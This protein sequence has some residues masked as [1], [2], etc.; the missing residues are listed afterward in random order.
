MTAVRLTEST[1]LL[2]ASGGQPK[3]RRFRAR[4]IAGD[5]QGSSGFYP[6]AMLR[7]SAT[8]FG[9]GLPMYID[10]PSISEAHDRPER[11]VR[12]LAGRLASDARYEADGLY[13][14]IEVYP[15][16][17]PIIEA[18]ADDIGLSIRASGTVE[19][20]T[21]DRIRGPIV[22]R[23]SEAQSVDFVTAAG[24]GGRL[25]QLL[26]SARAQALEERGNWR[27]GDH[28]RDR[29]GRFGHGNGGGSSSRTGGGS[30]AKTGSG[31][32]GG[33]RTSAVQTSSGS[34]TVAS[35]RDGGGTL[36]IGGTTHELSR[37]E[38]KDLHHEFTLIANSPLRSLPVG[39]ERT[40]TSGDRTLA[41]VKR[42]GA[43]DFTLHMTPSPGASRDDVAAAPGTAL[44]R[45]DMGQIDR[46]IGG[47][48]QAAREEEQAAKD[49]ARQAN[50]DAGAVNQADVTRR[51]TG[52][53]PTLEGPG[54]KG[55]PG[56]VASTDIATKNS[57][58]I[59][60]HREAGDDF[61]HLT[62]GGRSYA[63][64]RDEMDRMLSAVHEDE[65]KGGERQPLAD[66]DGHIFGTVTDVG[67]GRYEVSIDGQDP[68]TL[69]GSD[70]SRIE[71]A[72]FELSGARRFDGGYGAVDVIP[73]KD[74][75]VSV[76]HLGDDGRPVTVTFDAKSA[77]A[78]DHALD[79]VNEGF[80]QFDTS[81]DAPT[82][83]VTSQI[84]KTNVGSVEVRLNGGAWGAPG[85]YLTIMPTEGDAWGAAFEGPQLDDLSD[86]WRKSALLES[87]RAGR[88]DG[89]RADASNLRAWLKHMP[90]LTKEPSMPG[91]TNLIE[92]RTIGAWVESRLHLALTT[93]GDDM[94]GDGRLTREE[95]ITL[96]SAVGDA[97]QAFTARVEADAP[98]LYE[99]GPYDDP[100]TP[101][102]GE[103]EVSEA[104]RRLAEAAGITANDLRDAISA[105]VRDVYSG[106]GIHV[107][108][109]D[110]TDTWVVFC[111]TDDMGLGDADLFQQ[112]YTLT[113]R[114]VTLSGDP[115][116]VRAVT[117]YEPQPETE[118]ETGP[119]PTK[120]GPPAGGASTK[121]APGTAPA[122][123]TESEGVMPELTEEQAR[124]L[125][126]AA[127]LSTQLTEAMARLDQAGTQIA[128]LTERADAADARAAEANAKAQR[129]ENEN[130]ARKLVTEA[131][132]KSGIPESSHSG[133]TE[134]VLRDLP[135]TEQGTLD[136]SAF[137]AVVESAMT[138]K[139]T[140]IASLL[141]AAGVGT[142]RGLGESR[143][144]LSEADIDKQL[145]EAFA[146]LPGMTNEAAQIAANGRA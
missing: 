105:A 68:F 77:Q 24:A 120:T 95:R 126:E 14:D 108:V 48:E 54:G 93:L 65:G 90:D 67:R 104:V 42:T 99:R 97:L 15:H 135:T 138:A 26:E 101:E 13:A 81:P 84:V 56:T 110:W 28:P 8:A 136:T 118:P 18:M 130:T 32:G 41:V 59:T 82:S 50:I 5:I 51:T 80:D 121:T 96:S 128:Q 74:G 34:V 117:T 52:A 111:M 114:T 142:I 40:V 116:E 3:G 9:R 78:I 43:S 140:E 12:D 62:V 10:H 4:I 38:Y 134:A 76:R 55:M 1:D 146:G 125:A 17:A 86:A 98:Q 100:D 37:Q 27:E 66:E 16:W 127:T 29:M 75:K 122:T 94:Y 132:T 72:N 6:A 60:V 61:D 69:T 119:G 85:S 87:R 35:H 31:S 71:D 113:G 46:A 58:T 2:E 47:H 20:S 129:L 23:I 145:A 33:S 115:V 106:E 144:E 45:R 123:V 30:G 44:T 107:W 91:R 39:G 88:Y 112:T 139:N 73:A 103:A 25:V 141:E 133:L 64:T 19:A 7:E 109:R 21:D 70:A 36:T 83:G 57:G 79:V 53:P 102:P 143:P 92:G 124:Q 49:A 89:L 63:L 137:Q 22:T 131:L 11:S